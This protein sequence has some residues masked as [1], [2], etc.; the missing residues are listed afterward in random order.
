M[1]FLSFSL[2]MYNT[3][4]RPKMLNTRLEYR[5]E[6]IVFFKKL[7]PWAGLELNSELSLWAGAGMLADFD[8]GRHFI[9]TPSFGAGYYARGR[10]RH[11][12]SFPLEFRSQL[13]LAYQ[14]KNRS[15]LALAFSHTSNA[16]LGRPNPGE[17]VLSLYYHVPFGLLF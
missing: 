14:F 10:S 1:G 12:L 3:L 4:D 8:L 16:S 7:K 13:E 17:E 2:G 5:P 9:L 15:R 11:D 6:S